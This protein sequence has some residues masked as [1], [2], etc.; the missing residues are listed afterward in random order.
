MNQ[1]V[2][3]KGGIGAL[4]WNIHR[5]LEVFVWSHWLLHT[6]LLTIFTLAFFITVVSETVT[7]MYILTQHPHTKWRHKVLKHDRA[8]KHLTYLV[9]NSTIY[10]FKCYSNRRIPYILQKQIGKW[11]SDDDDIESFYKSCNEL[12]QGKSVIVSFK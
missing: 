11:I 5:V 12:R 9:K 1:S 4:A 10:Y 7:A 8:T 6:T 2:P 3:M